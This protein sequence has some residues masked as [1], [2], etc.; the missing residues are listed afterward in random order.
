MIGL[1]ANV[2]IRHLVQ[3]DPRQSAAATAFIEQRLTVEEPGFVTAVVMGEV[4]WVL[5]RI[6]RV[7]SARLAEVLERIVQT[8]TLVFEHEQQVLEAVAALA[9]GRAAFAD[10][11]IAAVATKAGCSHTVTFD[12]RASRLSGFQLIA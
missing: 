7:R 1:D 9:L 4:A 2:L 5:E 6:Y 12:K 3:D 10:A 11:L 8:R